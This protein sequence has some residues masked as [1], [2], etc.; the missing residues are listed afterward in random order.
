MVNHKHQHRHHQGHPQPTFPDDGAQGC[1]D[2]KE[3]ETGK[4]KGEFPVQLHLVLADLSGAVFVVISDGADP[5]ADISCAAEGRFENALQGRASEGMQEG[6]IAPVCLGYQIIGR[7][8][9]RQHKMIEIGDQGATDILLLFH[10]FLLQGISCIAQLRC[11]EHMVVVPEKTFIRS[12]QLEP[13]QIEAPDLFAESTALKWTGL[14]L[15]TSL[16]F[17]IV[18][19]SV[20]K[21]KNHR[22][23]VRADFHPA[24]FS[25][26]N[27]GIAASAP[28]VID[29]HIA[30]GAAVFLFCRGPDHK[31]VN[32]LIKHTGFNIEGKAVLTDIIQDGMEFKV[33]PWEDIV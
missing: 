29:H 24:C 23:L 16:G 1:T 22:A 30:Q 28:V 10:Q 32:P 12:V 6:I 18:I 14:Q 2:K 26:R 31:A 21:G 13:A 8:R 15:L 4:R 19:V 7:K 11:I 17:F 20:E 3:D 27:I 25:Q 9:I 33:C 5:F